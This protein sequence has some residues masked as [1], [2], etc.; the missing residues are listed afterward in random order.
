MRPSKFS[1]DEIQQALRQVEGG[2]PAVQICRK[3]G[4]TQTTFYRWR[5]KHKR[6]GAGG[7]REVRDLR[8]ENQKL[9]Q[10]VANLML[11]KEGTT[12]FGR[13]K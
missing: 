10:I 11:D 13:K 3:L 5:K 2:A 6:V 4:I 9:K 12:D 1:E 8:D 7:S